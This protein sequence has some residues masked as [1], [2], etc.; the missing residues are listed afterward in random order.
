[1]R[2]QDR[3]LPELH[4]SAFHADA[5]VNCGLMAGTAA[6]FVEFAQDLLGGFL[7]SQHIIGQVD[8]EIDGDT[9]QGE[10]YFYAQHR[11]VQNGD[12]VDLIVAGR[13]IDVYA[14][15]D[16]DWRIFKRYEIVDWA[17]TDPAAD[18]FVREQPQ[19]PR[20]GRGRADFSVT[21]DWP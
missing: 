3:L 13:Y 9:A 18:A 8:I 12:E 11:L 7:S 4:L 19:I 5:W 20:G 21:R 14:C 17:R 2:G 10:V 15:R 6:E 16:G 1:M